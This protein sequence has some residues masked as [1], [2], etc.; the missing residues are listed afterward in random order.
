M[1]LTR[2]MTLD[3]LKKWADWE[4][5]YNDLAD[6]LRYWEEQPVSTEQKQN[7]CSIKETRRLIEDLM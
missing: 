7:I 6:L 1:S 3:M 2:P 4:D 5:I